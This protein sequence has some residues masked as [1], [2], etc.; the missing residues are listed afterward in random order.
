MSFGLL[1]L[2]TDLQ[3]LDATAAAV[4]G[5]VGVGVAA[6]VGIASKL[7]GPV[8]LVAGAVS[9]VAFRGAAR[10]G[11]E[12]RDSARSALQLSSG[13]ALAIAA[14][15]PLLPVLAVAALGGQYA[16]AR[17]AI[18]IYALGTALAVLNQPLAGILAAGGSDRSVARVIGP[19]VLVG[20]VVGSFAVGSFGA[21]GMA[22][23]YCITQVLIFVACVAMYRRTRGIDRST[24]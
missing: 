18:V 24:R 12:A 6:D 2:S 1:G 21:P 13:F 5:G 17:T 15:S 20:L 11:P 19:A 22:I 10:G 23:G 8:G 14:A 9:Q 4:F 16:G 7:T 3:Q